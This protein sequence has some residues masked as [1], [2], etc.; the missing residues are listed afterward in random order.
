MCVT[1]RYGRCKEILQTIRD[2]IIPTGTRNH[3]RPGR[4]TSTARGQNH[5][6]PSRAW[7]IKPAH[8]IV[9][10]IH[11]P[12]CSLIPLLALSRRC[13]FRMAGPWVSHPFS[14]KADRIKVILG[15]HV[16]PP[17]VHWLIYDRQKVLCP[18]CCLSKPLVSLAPSTL[19]SFLHGITVQGAMRLPLF[20]SSPQRTLTYIIQPLPVH[21]PTNRQ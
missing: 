16:L 14:V 18:K 15:R 6:R 9:Q 8:G 2:H 1:N 12:T 7:S 4:I 3:K 20:F 13:G 5:N 11:G 21:L 17:A 10:G 19:G